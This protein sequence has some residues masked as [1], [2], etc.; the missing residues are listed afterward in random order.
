[1]P[2]FIIILRAGSRW[3]SSKGLLSAICWHTGSRAQERIDM[4]LDSLTDG[5]NPY[6][7]ILFNPVNGG[8]EDVASAHSWEAGMTNQKNW[9]RSTPHAN[10]IDVEPIE[11]AKA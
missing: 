4:C 1:M 10:V 3:Q 7:G 9:V 6:L 8:I 2:S 11:L 5:A